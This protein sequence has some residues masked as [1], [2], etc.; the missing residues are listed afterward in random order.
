LTTSKRH[1][2][3]LVVPF[4]WQAVLVPCSN[5][6]HWQPFGLP[7]PMAWQM[8]GILVTSAVLWWVFRLDQAHAATSEDPA[9]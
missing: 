5:R 2:W 4:V 9:P 1:R 8:A 6:V 3:L 7:F